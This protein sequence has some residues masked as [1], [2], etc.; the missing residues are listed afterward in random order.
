M[1]RTDKRIERPVNRCS[2]ADILLAFGEGCCTLFGS[3]D[4]ILEL[5]DSWHKPDGE[6]DQGR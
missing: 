5:L 2:Q 4:A 1:C 3:Q 6:R